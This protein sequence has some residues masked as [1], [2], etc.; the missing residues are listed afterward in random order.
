M[1]S[2]TKK[3]SIRQGTQPSALVAV[4]AHKVNGPVRIGA[5]A[6]RASYVPQQRVVA[7]AHPSV[8]DV[9][10][11]LV[12][13]GVVDAAA[14]LPVLR[15]GHLDMKVLAQELDKRSCPTARGH[16]TNAD[17]L[18][19]TNV[20]VVVDLVNHELGTLRDMDAI[21]K[22]VRRYVRCCTWTQP[23]RCATGTST[24]ASSTP[25]RL[26]LS[27][28][29]RTGRYRCR[30][31]RASYVPHERVVAGGSFDSDLRP[32]PPTCPA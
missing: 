32:A 8:V 26:P 21:V 20:L 14:A 6:M 1:M 17:G 4:T 24:R 3:S 16:S 9:C 22:V 10:E 30:R 13:R 15:D 7:G 27:Q 31:M 18:A 25:W 2:A 11:A 29:Q 12:E 5:V 28:G 23:R 19:Q